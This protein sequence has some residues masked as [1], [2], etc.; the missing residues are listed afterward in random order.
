MGQMGCKID[1]G[2][3]LEKVILGGLRF[4]LVSGSG[5]WNWKRLYSIESYEF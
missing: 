4:N 3:C 2:K 1:L 5:L